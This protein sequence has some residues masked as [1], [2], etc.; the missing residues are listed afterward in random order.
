V[1]DLLVNTGFLKS[2]GEARRAIQEG[3]IYLNNQRVAM[4]PSR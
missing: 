1:V 3:G 2:K 4:P